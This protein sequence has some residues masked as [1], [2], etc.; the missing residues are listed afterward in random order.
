MT[1]DSRARLL[2]YIDL[3]AM[4]PTLSFDVIEACCSDSFGS[5]NVI[6]LEAINHPL[7]DDVCPSPPR[8]QSIVTSQTLSRLKV[9]RFQL[10]KTE[11]STWAQQI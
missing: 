10:S 1:F 6:R 8:L 11:L 7:V 5:W 9:P 4:I 2:P 3:R